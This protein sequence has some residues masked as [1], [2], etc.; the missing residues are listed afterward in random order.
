MTHSE[1]LSGMRVLITRP[2]QLSKKL[3]LAVRN[4]GGHTVNFPLLEIQT[5]TEE[6]RINLLRY[7][8]KKLDVYDIL[9]FVSLLI[10]NINNLKKYSILSKLLKLL[11][12]I[13]I[14]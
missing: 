5:I 6:S 3:A 13:L 8:I 9:I 11:I 14:N 12:L 2:E 10:N 7:A 4:F 1:I